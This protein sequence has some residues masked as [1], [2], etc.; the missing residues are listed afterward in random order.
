MK[1]ARAVKGGVTPPRGKNK[2]DEYTNGRR[3]KG[4]A[5]GCAVGNK[6]WVLGKQA[7][8]PFLFSLA[9]KQGRRSGKPNSSKSEGRGGNRF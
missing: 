5:V 6:A 8:T 7:D 2:S 4:H 9:E 3:E 1:F